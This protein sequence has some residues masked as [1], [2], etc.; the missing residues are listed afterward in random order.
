MRI[1]EII[2]FERLSEPL[3][4]RQEFA[5]RL[6]RSIVIGALIVAA[7]LFGGMAGYHVF[8][9]LDWIDSF[10]NAAMILSGMGVLAAPVSVEGKLFA[11]LYAIFCGLV[12]IAATAIMFTPVIHRFLHQ[13]HMDD[14]DDA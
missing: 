12:L 8:E 13:M 14:E 10:V 9:G 3:A 11:G 2:A 6:V 7:A 4:T 1:P 5:G